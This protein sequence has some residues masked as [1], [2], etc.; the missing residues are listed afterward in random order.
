MNI[1]HHPTGIAF[2]MLEKAHAQNL[3]T[4]QEI[5]IMFIRN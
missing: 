5:C 2:Y 4:I 3:V 1:V